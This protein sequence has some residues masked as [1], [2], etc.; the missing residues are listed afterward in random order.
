MIEL[1]TQQAYHLCNTSF[2]QH[3]KQ[4]LKELHVRVKAGS[5]Y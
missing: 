4:M 5:Q 3:L 2:L 1:Y